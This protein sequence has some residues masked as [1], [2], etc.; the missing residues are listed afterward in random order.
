VKE[1]VLRPTIPSSEMQ[2]G[3]PA[4]FKGAGFAIAKRTTITEA[5][6]MRKDRPSYIGARSVP[7]EEEQEEQVEEERTAKATC[8]T[9]ILGEKRSRVSTYRYHP[10]T[11]PCTHHCANTSC[12][13]VRRCRGRSA[14]RYN[15]EVGECS[16]TAKTTTCQ[17][18]REA[19]EDRDRQ[20]ES[21]GEVRV[22]EKTENREGDRAADYHVV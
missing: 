14:A 3:R 11:K 6:K 4:R 20:I 9:R 7:D 15:H 13:R 2:V 19:Q 18:G 17:D 8:S 10:T 5:A 12:N 21:G 1:P 22:E 16:P